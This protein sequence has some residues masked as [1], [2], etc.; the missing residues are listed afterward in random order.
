MLPLHIQIRGD[1]VLFFRWSWAD[2]ILRTALTE[3]DPAWVKEGH[4]DKEEAL[5]MFKTQL[6]TRF[7]DGSYD[8]RYF[9]DGATLCR[10]S[11][12]H[13]NACPTPS[14]KGLLVS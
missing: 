13:L 11:R 3:F 9:A 1:V 10:Q 14:V 2:A 7:R 8:R 6:R 4:G 12:V 5:G